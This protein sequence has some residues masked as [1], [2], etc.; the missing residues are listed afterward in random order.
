MQRSLGIVDSTLKALREPLTI[1][2]VVIAILIQVT[3][4]NVDIGLIILSLIFL[5]RALTFL[6]A[7]QEQWNRFLG[8]SGSMNNM[9]EFTIELR[10]N[11]ER[12]GNLKFDTFKK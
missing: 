11:K 2:I 3:Y 10:K 1:L 9:T 5:Y 4:F 8:V 12:N 7:L 6:M